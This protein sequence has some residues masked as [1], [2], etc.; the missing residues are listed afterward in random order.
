MSRIRLA[1]AAAMVVALGPVGVAPVASAGDPPES[2]NELFQSYPITVNGSYVPL[3]GF[4]DCGA[5]GSIG[6]FWYAPGPAADHMWTNLDVNDSGQLE[7]SSQSVPVNGTYEPF[8]GDFDGDDCD[9]IFWYAPGAANDFVWYGTP[10]GFDS[11]PVTVKGTGYDPQVGDFD[12]DERD[13]IFWYSTTGGTESIWRGGATRGAFAKTTAPQVSYSGYRLSS[14]G[15][16]ILFHRPGPGQDYIWE[17]IEAG[18]PAPT[19][20]VP[21]TINGT[22]EPYFNFGILLYGPGSGPDNLIINYDPDGTLQTIGGTISGTY[23]AT[24][25]PPTEGPGGA[26]LFHAPGPATDYLW[27]GGAMAA[28]L[29]A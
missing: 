16:G 13:D 8:V 17:D 11:R 15:S 12:G 3:M 1:V 24:V 21:V 20:S 7:H 9:D 28:A 19:A 23:R 22:Y 2:F 10:T 26:I 4:L 5:G 25:P 27:I 14:F 18:A 6:F 29:R